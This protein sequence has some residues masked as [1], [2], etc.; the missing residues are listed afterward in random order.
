MPA[1]NVGVSSTFEQQRQVI[2]SIAVDVFALSTTLSGI[3]SDGLVVTYSES[4]GVATVSDY[5]SIAGVSTYAGLAG[6]ATVSVAS[7]TSNYAEVSGLST[8]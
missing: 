2:N 7:L 4:A 6:V 3:T 8:V 5:A 1:F